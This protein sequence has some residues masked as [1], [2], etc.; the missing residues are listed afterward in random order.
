[1]KKHLLFITSLLC[2][3]QHMHGMDWLKSWINFSSDSSEF[4]S[5]KQARLSGVTKDSELN[6]IRPKK[7]VTEISATKE[8]SPVI[9]MQPKKN[10]NKVQL[11]SEEI[12]KK[13]NFNNEYLDDAGPDLRRLNN[14]LWK[15]ELHKKGQ[16]INLELLKQEL[17]TVLKIY[18]SDMSQ[19][20]KEAYKNIEK[21]IASENIKS[22]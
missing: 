6:S 22:N 17:T 16:N 5:S 14:I 13:Y 1:M 9:E 4:S 12:I 11:F 8:E 10:K 20:A 18:G 19:E 21:N 15:M 2:I 3:S 7:T